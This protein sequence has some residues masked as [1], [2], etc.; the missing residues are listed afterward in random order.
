MTFFKA[1]SKVPSHAS[2]ITFKNEDDVYHV[3]GIVYDNMI[4]KRTHIKRFLIL[5]PTPEQSQS[6]PKSSKATSSKSSIK[7]KSSSRDAGAS[8]GSVRPSVN[9]IKL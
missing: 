3:E 8:R 2:Q 1:S 7:G 5:D 6:S 9:R 4:T